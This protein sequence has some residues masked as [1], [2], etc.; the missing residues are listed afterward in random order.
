MAGVAIDA[1]TRPS[2]LGGIVLRTSRHRCHTI[3]QQQTIFTE[4][5]NHLVAVC[6]RISALGVAMDAVNHVL[7]LIRLVQSQTIR[8]DGRRRPVRVVTDHASFHRITGATVEGIRQRVGTRCRSQ[9]TV[10]GIALVG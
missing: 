7:E 5:T 2:H 10:A 6:E 8:P 3:S 9:C 4:S 1:N